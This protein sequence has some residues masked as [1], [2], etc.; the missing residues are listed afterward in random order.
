MILIIAIIINIIMIA[1]VTVN[2]VITGIIMKTCLFFIIAVFIYVIINDVT[3][4]GF[5]H[6]FNQSDSVGLRQLL[7][8]PMFWKQLFSSLIFSSCR[9]SSSCTG[10]RSHHLP[11]K[12]VNQSNQTV[13]CKK[14]SNFPLGFPLGSTVYHVCPPF[15]GFPG[16]RRNQNDEYL[17]DSRESNFFLMGY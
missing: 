2:V 13:V 1:I 14:K 11:G 9:Q 12:T 15:P 6:S 10:R 16:G 5:V 8:F 17:F 7:F 3:V 4:F